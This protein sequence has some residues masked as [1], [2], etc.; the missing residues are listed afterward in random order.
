MAKAYCGWASFDKGQYLLVKPTS[1]H[2]AGG[3]LQDS[4]FSSVV[5]PTKDVDFSQVQKL[6]P[7]K[8]SNRLQSQVCIGTMHHFS[9]SS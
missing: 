4:G 3:G 8:S 1:R 6:D 5:L 9:A 7:F 2:V